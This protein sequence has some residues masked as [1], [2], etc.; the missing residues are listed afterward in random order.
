MSKYIGIDI[1]KQTF[2]V[3]FLNKN[4]KSEFRKFDQDQ[5][6]FS[7]LVKLGKEKIYV[8]EATGPYYLKLAT[9]LHSKG[10]QVAVVNPLVIKRFSQMELQRAKTDKKD[11]K[12]IHDYAKLKGV[13]LWSPSRKEISEMLQIITA[14]ELLHKQHNA[15]SNQLKAFITS[16]IIDNQV[17]KSI[18]LVIK[19]IENEKTQLEDRL[20][21]IVEE[22][23]AHTKKLLI[24]IPGIGYKGVA[25]LI[26]I[27]N[28]FEKFINYK[29]LIAYVGLSPRVYDSGTTVKGKGHI[30]KMGKSSARKILFMCAMSAKR[31]NKSCVQFSERL[32]AKGKHDRVIKIAIANKLIKIAFAVVTNNRYYDENFISERKIA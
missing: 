27:T 6:G 28:N 13:N 3:F 8:M 29:Q 15:S 23:F 16:G 4:Q 25:I 1:S 9:F 32:A 18:K 24:S 10:I 7:Q 11:A 30:C 20:N 17:K 31:H 26:A 5:K 14:L 22:N 12:T 21:Q 2:D 19:K